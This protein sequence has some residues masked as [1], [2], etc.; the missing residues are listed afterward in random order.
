MI[1]DIR[2]VDRRLSFLL[3]QLMLGFAK[4]KFLIDLSFCEVGR[5]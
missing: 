5:W 3:E 2:G 4:G 1:C